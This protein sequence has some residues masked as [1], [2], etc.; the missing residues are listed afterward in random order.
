MYRLLIEALF[1]DVAPVVCQERNLLRQRAVPRDVI[2][3]M[4]KRM[5]PPSIEEGFSA[6]QVIRG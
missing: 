1:F 3:A 2:E 6:V 5:V 4:A